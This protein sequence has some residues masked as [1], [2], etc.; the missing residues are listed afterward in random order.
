[1]HKGKRVSLVL[2]G[3]GMKGLAHIGVLKALHRRGI[4][5]DEYVGTSV[6]AFIA[7]MAAGGMTAQQVEEVGRTTRREDILD[8]NWAGLV[9]RRARARSIYRG[10]ALHDYI[11]RVLLEDQFEQLRRPLYVT[12]VNL[13][14]GEEVVW[15]MPGFT[16]LPVHDAVVSSCAIP[17]VFPPKKINRYHFVDGGV[18]DSLPIKIS[19][20]NKADLIIAVY[21][22]SITE[23]G[24]AIKNGGGSAAEGAPSILSQTQGIHSRTLM[25]FV[26]KHFKDAPVVL[27]HMNVAGYGLFDFERTP[28]LID[29]AE[30]EADRVFNEHPLL[31]S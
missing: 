9:L 31:R 13:D 8:Y 20:Y 7:A 24:A 10:K 22:D 3:G 15:G 12:A 4:E 28:E 14:S 17:G 5:P 19:V 29:A 27:V 18:A 23:D 26:L 1:M 11:R 25:K 16:E 21:L 30:R 2:G 6:G